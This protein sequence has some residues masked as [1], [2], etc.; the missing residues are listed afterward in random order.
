MIIKNGKQKTKA[1]NYY[2]ANKKLTRKMAR[3]LQKSF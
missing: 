2:Q 3:V 1:K